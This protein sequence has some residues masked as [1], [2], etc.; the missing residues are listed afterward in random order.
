M[1][2]KVVSFNIRSCDDK[3]GNSI[4]ERAPR[5]YKVTAPYDADVFGIQEYVPKWERG[6]EEFFGEK[7]EIFNKYRTTTGW[8]ESAPILWRKAK[9]KCLNKGYFW[10]SDTPEVE[11]FGGDLLNHNRICTYVLLEDKESGVRFTFM[12]THFGFGSEYQMK[13]AHLICEYAKKISEYP[14]FITGDFNLNPD[15]ETYAEITKVMNDVNAL[16]ANDWRNTFNKY[17]LSLDTKQHIDYCFVDN[18][19]KPL[20]YRMI[21]ELDNGKF[22]SDHFGL[23]IELD[24]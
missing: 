10:L 3:D 12:N 5:L 20:N 8:L 9:F 21:D 6:I 4:T 19:I 14:T 24:I 11:S 13:S 16:T 2:L 18:R 22:P 23:Y 17:D 15:S 1:K 7:Y